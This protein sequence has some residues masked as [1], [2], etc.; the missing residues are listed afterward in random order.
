MNS[1]VVRGESSLIGIKEEEISKYLKSPH[2]IIVMDDTPS[3]NDEVKKLA[4]VGAEVGLVV[5]SDHQIGGKGRRGRSFFSP[6]NSG[7]YMSML[8]RPDAKKT[9]DIIKL[10]S[11]AAVA[12][13]SAISEVCHIETGIK[14]VNDIYL[15]DK[16][17][18]GIL[19]ESVS[20]SAETIGTVVVGI[21][22][23]V[24]EPSAIPADLQ[25]II[26]YIYPT[27]SK[28]NNHASDKTTDENATDAQKKNNTKP[29]N[30]TKAYD[31]NDILYN[32]GIDI[33]NQIAAQVINKLYDFYYVTDDT[34]IMTEYLSRSIVLDRRIAY[35]ASL[36][37]T[38][39]AKAITPD[40][41]LIVEG[42]QEGEVALRS[43]EIS[44]RLL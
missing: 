26:G 20:A 31:I 2:K 34:E 42:D 1:N 38:G 28:N 33:R 22:I 18:C 27:D 21:G 12:V 19:A 44:L 36:E 29:D 5:I 41:V 43:G 7:I 40:G 15:G 23:N 8:F 10:T 11:Y 39:T 17:I 3:T 13:S 25:D 35:G 30:K 32:N 9:S 37:K 24:Y 6:E 14:W 16:K 4:A